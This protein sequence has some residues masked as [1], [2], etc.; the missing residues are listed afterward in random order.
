MGSVRNILFIMAD[1][2]RADYL[3]C[4][5][6]PFSRTP[7]IDGLAKRAVRFTR[8]YV[9]ATVCG[10]S[11]MSYYT[12]RYASSHGSTWNTIP[13][14][15]GEPTLGNHL[16]ALGVRTA[17]VGKTHM[18]ADWEGL[19]SL[20]VPLS[21]AEG[22]LA[23]EC[24]FEPFERDDGLHPN[25]RGVDQLAYNRYLRAHGYQGLNPWQSVANAAR[26][27]GKRPKSGWL[28][29]NCTLPAIVAD[30]HSETAYT[31]NRAMD[32][33]RAASSTPWCLH[34]SYIKPH[35]PYIAS[36]PYHNMYS[37]DDVIP[38][39]RN[40]SEKKDPHPVYAAYMRHVESKTF[41]REKVR[42]A[43]IPV[44]MGLLRQIDDHL[45]RLFAFMKSEGLMD[46]T[47]IVLCS[48]HG[49]YLGDHWL[50][51]KE[52]FHDEVSRVPLII[53]DPDP[54]AE[55][56]RGKTC[57][58]LVEAIDLAPTFIEAYQGAP[59]DHILEGRSLLPILRGTKMPK[60]DAVVSEL[61][62][63]LRQARVDLG[64]ATD[65]ARAWMVRT[66]RWK[67]VHFDG[68]PPQLFDHKNDPRELIDLG[69]DVAYANVTREHRERLFEWSL[70]RRMRIT[71][72]NEAIRASTQN[73]R[74]HGIIIGEW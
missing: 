2:L 68:F 15:V 12:G 56:M 32:F 29:R 34:L 4:Y 70:G 59:L 54:A 53:Y 11:R 14:R 71:I 44:Y 35:W 1:Q 65:K 40:K 46:N 74:E 62:Y 37:A 57:N 52:L 13:L 48:D 31:T 30:E 51:E 16:R 6:H 69:R 19:V 72:S 45:R 67:Y 20:R 63:C 42:H 61:D 66:E 50:G 9:N 22:V 25:G 27:K 36:A 73:W 64:V 7:A 58:D 10:P 23:A 18:A 28:M 21:S 24:G 17:L 38:A 26:G 41:S 55:K 47:M 39:N 49:D 3:S 5:G 33:M 8:A 43:V 60:H